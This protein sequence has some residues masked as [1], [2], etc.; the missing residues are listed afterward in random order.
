MATARLPPK[1]VETART[2]L[3]K[4]RKDMG[5]WR[6][7]ARS[8]Y[9]F[10]SGD[11]W[12]ESDK[13]LLTAQKR[14]PVTFNYSEKMIDAVVGAEVGN[15]QEVTYAPREMGDDGTAELLTQVAKWDRDQVDAEDQDSDA[16]RDMLICGL[17]WTETR[18]NY[19]RDPD[20][21]IDIERIDP[22]EMRYDT[23][24][25]KRGLSDRRW[26]AR[27]WWVDE[28]DARTEWPDLL[29]IGG[30]NASQNAG[31]ID[32]IRYG[33]RYQDDD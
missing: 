26:N 21:L 15:R 13:T 4:A 2:R 24:A 5:P 19:E 6:Q 18:M 27:E 12:L 11:Q 10:V 30:E 14:P 25:S 22:L 20:G 32:H 29:S 3:A 33:H 28:H 31:G 23:A 17:G 7:E 16:F 8:A 9:A 1:F